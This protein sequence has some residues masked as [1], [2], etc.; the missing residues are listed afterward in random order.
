MVSES[1]RYEKLQG[2]PNV[3]FSSSEKSVSL[4]LLWDDPQ[5]DE[6]MDRCFYGIYSFHFYCQNCRNKEFDS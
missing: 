4:H 1:S 2:S 3:G 6:D 5:W